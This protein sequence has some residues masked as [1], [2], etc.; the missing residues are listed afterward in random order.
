M[1]ASQNG[2]KI[3]KHVTE[4]LFLT[5]AAKCIKFEIIK[6]DCL[7]FAIIVCLFVVVLVLL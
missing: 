2:E 1:Y 7:S 3:S 4:V 6:F 5:Y